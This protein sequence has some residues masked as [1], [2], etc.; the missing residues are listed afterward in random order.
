M[1][2]AYIPALLLAGLLILLVAWLPLALRRA[3]LS[4]PIVCVAIGAVLGWIPAVTTAIPH[5]I[6]SPWLIEKASELVVIVSLMG[7]GLKIDHPFSF[8][9][10][11]LTWRLLA[12]TM[13]L[14]ILAFVLAGQ[15]LLGLALPVPDHSTIGRRAR[16]IKL[17][18]R[19]RLNGGPL[20]LL[21]DSTGLKLG[22]PGEWLTEKHGTKRRR[23]WRVLHI[24]ME[25]A[26]G[27]IVAATLTDR[28]VDDATQVGPLLDQVADPVASLT[29]DGAFD[30][31]SV[32]GDVHE[33]HPEAAVIVPPRVDEALSETVETATTQRDR[34]IQAIKAKGRI[35]WQRD[36]GYNLRARVESQI[37]RWKRVIGDGLRFHTDEAQVTEVAIAVEVLNCMLDL[38]RP[39]SVR[40]A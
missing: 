10:W 31:S 23:S 2:A 26:S 35:A 33:R 14:S 21:V 7:A 36:S 19:P 16:T 40:F 39:N 30:R 6:S 11:R 25:A 12:V 8:G 22:G 5:P 18:A 15:A 13:P 17:P 37:G 20:H 28:G 38:G 1:T 27:R 29:G 24:G 4:L 3:P 34:H 9:G 32:Y